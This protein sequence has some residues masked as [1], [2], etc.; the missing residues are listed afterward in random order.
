MTDIP[1]RPARP[2]DYERIAAVADD[3]WGRPI[4]Q[5]LPRLFLDHFHRTS[6]VAE[7]SGDR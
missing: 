4:L 6:L 5:V 3:W 2:E 7:R 1:L